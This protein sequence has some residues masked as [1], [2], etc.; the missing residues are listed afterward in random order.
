MTWRVPGW[1]VCCRL[2]VDCHSLHV[3]VPAG[4]VLSCQAADPLVPLVA[5]PWS[6]DHHLL[7]W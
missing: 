6:T 7:D 3:A 4:R 5:V 2:V 1:D